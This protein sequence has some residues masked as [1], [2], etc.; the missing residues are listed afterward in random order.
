ME[1]PQDK[2]IWDFWPMP[3]YEPRASQIEA[4]E[5]MQELP[6]HIKYV[7]CEIPVGGGKSPIALN[8]TGYLGKSNTLG[9]SF[10]LTPQRI[11]QRQY[12]ESFDS[13]LLASIYGKANYTCDSKDTNCDIGSDIK[14][15]CED[16]PAKNAFQ[17]GLMTPNMVL[18]YK[19]GL[20]YFDILPF[21]LLPKRDLMV[22]D[23]CHTLEGHLTDHRALTISERR[24]GQ[25]NTKFVQVKTMMEAQNWVRGE[26]WDALYNELKRLSASVSEISDK[27]N[28]G[29]VMTPDEKRLVQRQKEFARHAE[30]VDHIRSSNIE[31]LLEDYV[32]IPDKTIVTF[33]ELY[34]KNI[35]HSLVKPRA[36]RFLFLSSTIMGKEAFCA[37]LGINPEEAEMI[38][39]GSEFDI[40]N[41]RVFFMPATKMAFGWNKPENKENRDKMLKK[42]ETLCNEVHPEDCGVI[43]TGRDRKSVV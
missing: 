23:E 33:K 31:E 10:I 2:T 38:S 8:Y 1:S 30:L 11:L 32:L 43:H 6:A 9:T 39:L 21:D 19:L 35:F 17:K 28:F 40:D 14:P 42:I 22:F 5:W 41:R 29:A 20:L 4:L 37:D 16:C 15:K 18:N 7:L 12:E 13:K 25:L 3:E 34:G 27:C 36:N 24:C 26:Y